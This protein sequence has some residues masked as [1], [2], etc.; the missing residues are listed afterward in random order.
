MGTKYAMP[1][2]TADMPTLVEGLKVWSEPDD[3]D[4]D[5]PITHVFVAVLYWDGAAALESHLIDLYCEKVTSNGGTTGNWDSLV[6]L[7]ANP[8]D[9]DDVVQE[10]KNTGWG[11]RVQWGNWYSI[12]GQ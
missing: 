6:A 2:S 12:I 8:S 9:L 11:G 3:G 7:A 10:M 5:G 4:L 1:A